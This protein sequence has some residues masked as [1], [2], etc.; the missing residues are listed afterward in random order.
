MRRPTEVYVAMQSAQLTRNDIAKSA[1]SVPSFS[2][3]RAESALSS[4]ICLHCGSPN[5]FRSDKFCCIGC[6]AVYGLLQS[7]GLARFYDLRGERGVPFQEGQSRPDHLWIDV[8]ENTLAHAAG[9]ER[10]VVDIQ[11]IHCAAC[12]WLLQQLFS[13]QPGAIR[14]DINPSLG[15]ATLLVGKDFPLRAYVE[16]VERFGYVL[17]PSLKKGAPRASS[18]VTRM[19][20]CIAIAMNSMIFAIA[21]YAGLDS[22]P[23]FQLF[24]A[25]VFALA[26][27]SVV[28][29]GWVFIRSATQAAANRIMHIDIP[30]A[31]G[32]V[33]AFAGS[34]YSYFF[35]NSGASYFDTLSV[36]IALMLVGRWLQE[37][38]IEKNRCLLLENDGVD[39]LLTRRIEAKSVSVVRCKEVR[40]GDRLLVSSGELVPVE[41]LLE[42]SAVLSLEWINGESSPKEFASRQTIPAGSFNAGSSSFVIRAATD[43]QDSSIVGLIRQTRARDG[44]TAR[45]SD[46][47]QS[48]T[49]F[50]VMG[51]LTLAALGFISW[52]T[53][54]HDVAKALSVTTAVL[55]VTCPCAFGIATPLGYE[56]VQAGLRRAGLFIRT[57]GFL[58]RIGAVR[59]VVFDKTGTLTTGNLKL[60]NPDALAQLT[61]S[62]KTALFNMVARSSHPKSAALKRVLTT[63]HFDSQ[64]RVTELPGLGLELFDGERVY[65]LGSAD[66]ALAEASDTAADEVVFSVCGI[67]RAS[68]HLQE[69]L[70]TDAVREIAKLEELGLEVWIVSGDTQEKVDAISATVGVDPARALGDHD[71]AAKERFLA[72]HDRHDT[73]MIG[74]GLNDSLAVARA[75]CSGTPAVDRPFVASRADFYFTTPGLEPL[76]TAFRA[77]K[78]LQRVTRRNL[79]IALG[80]N[81]IAVALS[82]AGWMS[83]LLCAVFMPVSSLSVVML[84]VASLSERRTLWKF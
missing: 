64:Y 26:T 12:V 39:G 68:F 45:S 11:G 66:W 9:P 13:R 77:S 5:R 34:A 16:K 40:K 84:T 10:T 29:G 70:R 72:D 75:F 80:Y 33:L 32:I 24:G 76:G 58:D 55:I 36:F 79:A 37:R 31:L 57:S 41:G 51:V 18:L 30:I 54:T 67:G 15:K 50:Y 22:G 73:M 43:F 74:D 60:V 59:R 83:P 48:V 38:V 21:I 20:V 14:I 7:E 56:L 28:I 1:V 3:D 4:G 62:E 53:L 6:E 71:P 78:E 65:R 82:Y 63:Q 27:F 81:F 17:G 8:V 2:R 19:G 69:E 61:S 44:E 35:G 46:W 23:I 42:G 47:W 52:F 49:K 25:I